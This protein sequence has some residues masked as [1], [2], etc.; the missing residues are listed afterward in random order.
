MEHGVYCYVLWEH[1]SVATYYGMPFVL[2]FQSY[3]STLGGGGKG[4]L[5]TLPGPIPIPVGQPGVPGPVGTE[6]RIGQYV[7]AQDES[8]VAVACC[9]IS[10]TGREG[11][12][13][14]HVVRA[15]TAEA[16]LG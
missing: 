12:G 9:S 11:I 16:A 10:N 15:P 13:L 6:G 8:L 1:E 7:R 4:P 3:L 5:N 2:W 14:L